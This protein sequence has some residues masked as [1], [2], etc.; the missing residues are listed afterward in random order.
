MASTTPCMHAT[1]RLR[2]SSELSKNPLAYSSVQRH[3]SLWDVRDVCNW[4][5]VIGFAQYRRKFSHNR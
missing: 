2:A 1:V 5:E 3:P 4:V